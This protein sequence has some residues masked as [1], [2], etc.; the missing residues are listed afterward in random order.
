MNLLPMPLWRTLPFPVL[1][2][3]PSLC[4]E[5]ATLDGENVRVMTLPVSV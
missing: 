3:H 1:Y 2:S 4:P 5:A